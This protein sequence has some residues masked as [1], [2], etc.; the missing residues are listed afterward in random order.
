MSLGAPS[1]PPLSPRS[2]KLHDEK[3]QRERPANEDEPTERTG[4]KE[5]MQVAE[6]P[7]QQPD[8][9]RDR[10]CC[11][12]QPLTSRRSVPPRSL[13]R[14]DVRHGLRQMQ[15]LHDRPMAARSPNGCTIALDRPRMQSPRQTRPGATAGRLA[16]WETP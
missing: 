11:K 8:P 12:D 9:Q 16:E 14:I 10:E 1:K 4:S 2:P 3:R 13:H 5:A 7:D 6:P 15:W